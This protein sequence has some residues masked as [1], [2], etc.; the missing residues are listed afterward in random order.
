MLLMSGDD[1]DVY[2]VSILST[3]I[4]SFFS[5]KPRAGSKT[6]RT[7]QIYRS[8]TKGSDGKY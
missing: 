1:C 6:I 2:E 8:S 5:Q 4:S 7:S 3:I